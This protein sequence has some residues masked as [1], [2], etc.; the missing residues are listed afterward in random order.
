MKKIAIFG[1]SGFGKE[2]ACLLNIINSKKKK[3]DFVG[4][5]DDFVEVETQISHFGQTLGGINELNK[6]N[7]ELS[8]IIALGDSFSR[9]NVYEKISNKHILF[10]NICYPGFSID[11]R[12]IKMGK[13]NVITHEKTLSCDI[14]IGDFNMFNSKS[15][16][17]GHDVKIGSFN[18]FMPMTAISGNVIIGNCN[19]FGVNAVV[20]PKLKIGDNTKISAGSIVYRNTKDDSVYLGNPAKKFNY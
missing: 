10:P 13:G 6:V 12:S 19:Y 14:E 16:S 17:V 15:A 18:S 9:K 20:L 5:Y 4:F 7:E 1:A 11:E 2:I 3:W 8:I